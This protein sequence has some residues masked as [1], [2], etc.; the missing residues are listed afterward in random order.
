MVTEDLLAHRLMAEHSR[1]DGNTILFWPRAGSA[2]I[3][4][5]PEQFAAIR[6]AIAPRTGFALYIREMWFGGLAGLAL[7]LATGWLFAGSSGM[8][9]APMILGM[10]MGADFGRRRILQEALGELDLPF[11]DVPPRSWWQRRQDIAVQTR[12]WTH[13]LMLAVATVALLPFA[14]EWA[15]M[16]SRYLSLAV[17]IYLVSEATLNMIAARAARRQLLPATQPAL[18]PAG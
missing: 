14:L 13:I 6:R 5:A 9:V 18:P 4:L 17:A 11:A 16:F 15:S 2:G 12:P 10:L 8:V 7:G 1:R 3:H